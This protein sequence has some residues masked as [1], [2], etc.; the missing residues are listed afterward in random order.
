MHVGTDHRDERKRL[1]RGFRLAVPIARKLLP[2]LFVFLLLLG[3][4]QAVEACGG[5]GE[6]PCSCTVTE[7][8]LEGCEAC[9]GS[10][11]PI[12]FANECTDTSGWPADCGGTNE[13]VC[14][15]GILQTLGI[16][17][18]KPGRINVAGTCRIPDSDGYPTFCGGNGERPCRLN[19]KFPACKLGLLDV[20]GTCVSLASLATDEDGYP[21][22]CGDI[23]EPVCLSGVISALLGLGF[24]IEPCKP[25]PTQTVVAPFGICTIE[26][27]PNQCGRNG[28]R[29]CTLLEH[30]PSCMSGLRELLSDFGVCGTDPVDWGESDAD[31]A[32]RGGPR[33]VFLI[34]GRGGDY[35][36]FG[37]DTLAKRLLREAPNVSQVYGIDWHNQE[38]ESESGF[39]TPPAPVR[40]RKLLDTGRS[41]A[42]HWDFE[43]ESWG[44]VLIDAE[45]Y[46]ITQVAFAA[47]EAIRELP[48]ESEIT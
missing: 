13:P 26:D 11:F 1:G 19:E 16:G 39:A 30:I 38:V 24:D 7:V 41:L 34:H 8:I 43:T 2:G 20:G 29:P 28:Q 15:G 48:T 46:E 42:S 18:C 31:E 47:A 9:R 40:S 36:E 22:T 44:S 25:H 21:R 6:E 32:P 33:T 3:F 5:S 12:P 10:R 17:A 4:G 35:S 27:F 45:S 37:K 23:G 14:S